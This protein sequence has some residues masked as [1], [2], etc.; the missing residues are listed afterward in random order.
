V[1]IQSARWAPAALVLLRTLIGWHFLYEGYFKLVQ[2]AWGSAGAPLSP[3]SAAGFLRGA[4]GPLGG[5][6]RQL[7]E[8]PWLTV[9]D[10]AIPVALAVTGLLL[11]LGLFTQWASAAAVVLLL[12]FYIAA[13]PLSG[14]PD[15]RSE[16]TYLVVNKTLVEAAAALAVFAFRTGRIAGLDRVMSRRA[17]TLNPSEVAA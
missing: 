3:W 13:V 8:P 4:S 2:P 6:F 14:V 9:V 15:L 1:T 10:T 16:G 11:M 12:T 7:A 17:R 5:L